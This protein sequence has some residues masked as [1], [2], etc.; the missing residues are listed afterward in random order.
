MDSCA[1][2]VSLMAGLCVRLPQIP[3]TNLRFLRSRTLKIVLCSSTSSV[4]SN[5]WEPFIK[6]KVVMRVGYVGSDYRG[7][8]FFFHHNLKYLNVVFFLILLI[9]GLQ[10]QR[11]EHQLSSKIFSLFLLSI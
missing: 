10:M 6:K 5:K 9:A 3:L 4:E 1:R 8:F 11:D 7:P 2:R